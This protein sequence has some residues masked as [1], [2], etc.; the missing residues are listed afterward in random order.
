MPEVGS[1]P[2]GMPSHPLRLISLR[3]R[4]IS[5]HF[6]PFRPP[7]ISEKLLRSLDVAVFRNRLC[8]GRTRLTGYVSDF[9]NLKPLLKRTKID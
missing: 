2:E 4:E 5:L 1:G 7:E 3:R 9:S 6:L 8:M